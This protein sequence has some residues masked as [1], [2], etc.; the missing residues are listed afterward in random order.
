MMTV[1]EQILNNRPMTRVVQIVDGLD[2]YFEP[3]ICTPG[4]DYRVLQTS[5]IGRPLQTAIKQLLCDG[6]RSTK[7]HTKDKYKYSP[8]IQNNFRPD[9]SRWFVDAVKIVKADHVSA[10]ACEV[11]ANFERLEVDRADVVVVARRTY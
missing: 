2:W 7:L 5:V 9:S 1:G 4:Q 8:L 6:I 3:C 11:A 10:F